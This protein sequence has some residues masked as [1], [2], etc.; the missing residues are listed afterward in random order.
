VNVDRSVIGVVGFA[1]VATVAAYPVMGPGAL[2]VGA[3]AFFVAALVSSGYR[4][5]RALA[6]GIVVTA[7]LIV[8]WLGRGSIGQL[9]IIAG[10]VLFIAGVFSPS[11]R[12]WWFGQIIE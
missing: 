12:R 8:G 6:W 3:T 2:V 1:A 5:S 10:S 9:L 4:V 7:L 11:F